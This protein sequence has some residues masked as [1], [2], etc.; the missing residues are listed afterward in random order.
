MDSHPGQSWSWL[1]LPL[2]FAVAY[3]V[4]A[5]ISYWLSRTPVGFATFWLPNGLALAVLLTSPG[6][7]WPALLLAA[8]AA[9]LVSDVLIHHETLVLSLAF[10]LSNIGEAL[11]GAWLLCRR[12]HRPFHLHGV[13]DVMRLTGYAA[14]LSPA[15][16]AFVGAVPL[17]LANRIGGIPAWLLCWTG[18]STGI[19]VITPLALTIWSQRQQEGYGLQSRQVLEAVALLSVLTIVV[20][21][22]FAGPYPFFRHTYVLLPLLLWAALRFQI[23]GAALAMMVV[24]AVATRYTAEGYG[25]FAD[26]VLSLTERMLLIQSFVGVLAWSTLMLAA[27]ATEWR[28][29]LHMLQQTHQH[30]EAEVVRRTQAL[31]NA[32]TALQDEITAHLQTEAALRESEQQFRTIANTAPAMLWVID[33]A[34]SCSFLSRGWYEFTGQSEATGL[35][36]G[37]IE[38][39]HPEDREDTLRALLAAHARRQEF[40]MDYRLRRADGVYHWVISTGRPRFTDR[41]EFLG[42][43]GS[44]IDITERK[45]AE[46]VLQQTRLALEQ[47]VQERTAAL[48]TANTVLQHEMA[49]RVRLEREVQRAEHFA[50]LGRLAADVSHDIRSPL[51]AVLLHVDLLTEELADPSQD[52]QEQIT[53]SLHQIKTHLNQ[54]GDLVQDYLSL[55]RVH[56][57]QREVQDLGTVVQTWSAEFQALAVARGMQVQCE[58]LTC[59]GMVALHTNTLRRAVLNL[60]QNALDAMAPGGTVTLAGHS[61]ATEVQLRVHDTG[62]GIPPERLAQIFEPLYTTKPGGT[63]LGLHIVQEVVTAHGG[64]VTVESVVGQGTTFTITLPRALPEAP[65]A[66]SG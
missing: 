49:A 56:T 50:S 55:L 7:R 41:G 31:A 57:I 29:L 25:V 27:V 42:Y 44:V 66:S 28:R 23:F 59:L 11:L 21:G 20:L 9:D 58:A 19:L 48:A 34:A 60:V 26:P 3:V 24:A 53:K 18:D 12:Q 40:T 17:A 30:L 32:N 14:L 1:A 63:G 39:V 54:L 33:P 15:L 16:S 2:L 61:T 65:T 47:R 46:V 6:R 22:I 64:Q 4:T 43:I 10:A 35:G 38:A 62:S 52:S 13:W 8:L 45:Q 51:A 37:W 36:H 5:E